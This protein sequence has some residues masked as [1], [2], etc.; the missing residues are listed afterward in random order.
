MTESAFAGHLNQVRAG[1][2]T[3]AGSPI[4]D[5]GVVQELLNLRSEF[6]DTLRQEPVDFIRSVNS[7][8]H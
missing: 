6:R 3:T 1:S 7:F 4:T 2:S 5:L 8:V